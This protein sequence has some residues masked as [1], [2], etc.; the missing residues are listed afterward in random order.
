MGSR[1]PRILLDCDGVIADFI[2]PTLDLIYEKTGVRYL[3]S[4]IT[5]WNVFK[6]LGITQ[7][8]HILDDAIAAGG[9]CSSFPLLPGAKEAVDHLREIGDVYVVT[10]PYDSPWWVTE[11]ASWLK[12]HFGFLKS[13]TVYTSAKHVVSGDALIDD[14]E[15]NLIPW[16]EHN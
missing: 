14:G 3:E 10:S 9:F 13:H 4:A 12:R 1:R 11:R 6:A 8:E 16:L 7:L 5:E 2:N 15:K